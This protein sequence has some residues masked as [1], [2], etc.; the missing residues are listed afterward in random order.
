MIIFE[1]KLA[2]MRF[3]SELQSSRA[4]TSSRRA[5]AS[6]GSRLIEEPEDDEHRNSERPGAECSKFRAKWPPAGL[7]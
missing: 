2:P 7:S 5:A 4:R 6:A 1:G 3:S